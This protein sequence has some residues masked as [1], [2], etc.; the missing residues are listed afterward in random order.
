MNIDISFLI[1]R[2]VMVSYT[3]VGFPIRNHI[4]FI[5]FLIRNC[6]SENCYYL[7][8]GCLYIKYKKVIDRV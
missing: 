8:R 4:F 2:N 5:G 7:T 1:R 6:Y 3:D